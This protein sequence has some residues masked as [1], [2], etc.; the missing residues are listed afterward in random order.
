MKPAILWCMT[1]FMGNLSVFVGLLFVILP[2]SSLAGT[3]VENS[4][5]E[6]AGYDVVLLGETH[7]N[8][9]HHARQQAIVAAL[10]PKAIVWEMLTQEQAEKVTETLIADQAALESA[11]DWESSGWP[12]FDLYFPVFQAM[13]GAK[14]YGGHLPR[15]AARAAFKTGIAAA[16]GDDANTYGLTDPLAA[17]EQTTRE[18]SQMQAHCD[19]LP[20]ELLPDMVAIQRLRDAKLAQAVVRAIAATGGPVVVITGTGHAR[21]DWGVPV[22]LARVAPELTVFAF[23]Q[24]EAGQIAGEF[25]LI[26]DS[27]MVDRD[28]PCAA[29]KDKS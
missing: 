14:P 20:E 29:F 5:A 1:A 24:S 28:D 12:S 26:L 4:I 8:P 21:K 27:P 9:G 17:D 19:A 15:P 16:F 2:V 11:L 6:M 25:D 7:D 23:G 3:S 13:P 10:Q 22:Y 18:A